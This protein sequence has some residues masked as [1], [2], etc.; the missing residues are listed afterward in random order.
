MVPRA[1]AG[2]VLVLHGGGTRPGREAVS[3]AQLSVLRMIP[4]A[5]QISRAGCG[6]LAVFRLLNSYR[7]WDTR[8]TPVQDAHWALGEISRRLGR[9]LPTCLVGHSL[10]GRAALLAA[11]HPAAVSVIA[12]APWLYAHEAAEV[13]G[14]QVLIVHGSRDR[15]ASRENSAEF[16]R[17]LEPPAAVSYVLVRGETHALLRRRS[18]VAGLYTGFAVATLLHREAG[19]PAG[20]LLAGQHWAE[21]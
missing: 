10:G 8:H 17:S 2:A 19:G 18:V 11:D 14:R 20:T 1:A 15:V 6:E 5:R 7:G 16:A 12:L 3:P 21:V 13:G 9:S 4:V